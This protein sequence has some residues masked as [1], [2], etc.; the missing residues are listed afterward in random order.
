MDAKEK[1]ASNLH[2]KCL[3]FHKNTKISTGKSFVK[4]L[5]S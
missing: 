2:E 4:M 3:S 5:K 1:K